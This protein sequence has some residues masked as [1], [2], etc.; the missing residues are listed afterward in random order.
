M[1][2]Q[3]RRPRPFSLRGRDGAVFEHGID[4]HVAAAEGLVWI[5]QGRIGRRTLRQPSQ[6]SRFR[7]RQLPGMLAEIKPGSRLKAIDSVPEVDLV[8]VKREN[9][10]LGKGALD[11]DGEEG[12]LNLA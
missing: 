4:D 5:D 12:F 7:Q 8:P 2:A 1:Q 6:Q 3:W 10:L 9:L 11:L